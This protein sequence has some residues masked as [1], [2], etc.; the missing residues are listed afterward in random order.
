MTP[1]DIV[2]KV[3]GDYDLGKTAVILEITEN[4]L[5]NTTVQVF[6]DGEIKNWYADYLEVVYE[7]EENS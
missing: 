5:G 2:K 4:D 7:D 1:G 6:V 3:T